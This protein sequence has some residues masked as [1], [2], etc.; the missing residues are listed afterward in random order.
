MNKKITFAA[1]ALLFIGLSSAVIAHPAP[2]KKKKKKKTEQVANTDSLTASKSADTAKAMVVTDPHDTAQIPYAMLADTSIQVMDDFTLDSTRPVDGYYKQTTLRGAKPYA[3]PTTS[4]NN[5]KKYKRIWRQIDLTDSVNAIFKIPD[6]E[7]MKILVEA[8]KS[9]KIIAYKDDEFKKAYTY[10][11]VM[12][13]FVRD[14]DVPTTDSLGNQT[15]TKSKTEFKPAQVKKYEIKED[16]YFDKVHGKLITEI[17]SFAPVTPVLTST[18]DDAGTETHPFYLN[19]VQLRRLLASREVTDLKRDISNMSYD[20]LLI[21]GNF[22]SMI[23]KEANPADKS[24][25]DMYSDPADQ[26]KESKR[27]EQEIRNYQKS[28]W[29]Y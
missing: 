2:G 24:I 8:I 28:L 26:L 11:D 13:Q 15:V 25:K 23:I 3:L 29:K 21:T 5:I 6:E 9:G 17:I 20:D 4:I 19:F 16:L 14:V 12:K 7:L 22:H 27:I 1:I 10:N 18:G